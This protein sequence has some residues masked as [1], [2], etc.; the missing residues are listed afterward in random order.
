MYIKLNFTQNKTG[1]QVFRILADIINNAATVTSVSALTT[2]FANTGIYTAGDLQVGFDSANS[3]LIVTSPINTSLTRAH[4]CR[5]LAVADTFQFTLEQSVYDSTSTKYYT[6]IYSTNSSGVVGS[7][8]TISYTSHSTSGNF[9]C[10][11]TTLQI[12]DR[13]TITGTYT[14][15]GSI[16]GYVS[17]NTYVVSAVAGTSPTVTGFTLVSDSVL[18]TLTTGAGT[19]TGLTFQANTPIYMTVGDTSTSPAFDPTSSMAITVASRGASTSG[20]ALTMQNTYTPLGSGTT[21]NEYM[22]MQNTCIRT[23][24]CYITD[25]TFLIGLN[26]MASTPLGWNTAFAGNCAYTSSGIF[27]SQYTRLDHW[28]T[29]SNG[30]IPVFWTKPRGAYNSNYITNYGAGLFASQ[31]DYLNIWSP[32]NTVANHQNSVPTLTLNAYNTVP[33]ASSYSLTKSYHNF[34]AYG[35]GLKSTEQQAMQ[36]SGA[37][38]DTGLSATSGFSGTPVSYSG[39]GNGMPNAAL[40]SRTYH[41]HPITWMRSNWGAYGGGNVSD[42]SA[43]YVF[44]G[45][46]QAGDEFSYNSVTYSIWPSAGVLPA[47]SRLGIAVPKT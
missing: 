27:S 8:N 44:N 21:S 34:A 30:V 46:Y 16:T 33:S 12:G 19:A 13:V 37:T 17:G 2:R 45:D 9:V 23:L 3:E 43:F 39:T 24:W 40:T 42:Q 14:G 11:A 29:S 10:S 47:T 28:N 26:G 1:E 7:T 20:T 18:G 15:T 22:S 31:T 4:V 36:F 6:R 35:L 25:K 38:I 32:E 41:L 5:N